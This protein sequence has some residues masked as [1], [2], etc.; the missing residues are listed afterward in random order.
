[1]LGW[2]PVY[3]E[4][5][6]HETSSVF[7]EEITIVR[8]PETEH[9]DALPIYRT[10]DFS[11]HLSHHDMTT[12]W[13]DHHESQ[14]FVCVQQAQGKRQNRQFSALNKTALFSAA[15]CCRTLDWFMALNEW[16]PQ[17]HQTKIWCCTCKH[18]VTE[19]MTALDKLHPRRWL[20][21]DDSTER[22]AC[23][24]GYRTLAA[25]GINFP[26]ELSRLSVFASKS[27]LA[28][29]KTAR[30]SNSCGKSFDQCT[31]G[32]V[33]ILID[34]IWTPLMFFDLPWKRTEQVRLRATCNQGGISIFCCTT[35]FHAHTLCPV[36]PSQESPTWC[37]LSCQRL[38]SSR[39]PKP[40]FTFHI[41]IHQFVVTHFV[42][43]WKLQDVGVGGRNGLTGNGSASSLVTVPCG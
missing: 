6:T 13:T 5:N 42:V 7:F 37:F 24:P 28:S 34:L 23:T 4:S 21:S 20:W 31:E 12:F 3:T 38:Q 25:S 40:S 10:Q 15:W 2:V 29:H 35:E 9:C 14:L 41:H 39:S 27:Q 18:F 30:W 19:C 26:C 22:S 32:S 16:S 33:T 17:P 8:G 1:M 43:C 36:F 11:W